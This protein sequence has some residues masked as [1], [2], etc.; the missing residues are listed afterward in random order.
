MRLSIAYDVLPKSPSTHTSL[1]MDHFGIG[2]ETGRHVIAED[3]ELPIEPGQ[4]VLFTGPSGAGKSSLLRA[5]ADQLP[6]VIDIN[7]LPLDSRPLIDILATTSPSTLNPHPSTFAGAL[8]LLTACGLGE[9]RLLLRTPRELSDGQRYRF[10]L[11]VALAH[12]PDWILADEFTATLDRILARIIAFNLH[13]LNERT[14]TGF[15]LAT[16][17][18]DILE[19]LEPHLHVTCTL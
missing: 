3:L 17:H 8:H 12:R 18:E 5:A 4:I 6:N 2:F 15:L 7:Q 14:N 1:V 10:R 11:A 16:T 19:D 9:P 13:R